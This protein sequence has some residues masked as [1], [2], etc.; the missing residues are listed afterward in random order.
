MESYYFL[1]ILFTALWTGFGV[2]CYKNFLHN[3]S[4]PLNKKGENFLPMIVFL[5]VLLRIIIGSVY[6]GHKT[7]MGCFNGWSNSVY[8]NGISNF[9][10]S[11]SFHD[12]PPGY[13]YVLFIIGWL[14]DL[15]SPEGAMLTLLLKAP[16]II[17]DILIGVLIYKVSCEKFAKNTSSII[18]AL[19][20]FNP[21][22]IVD[23]TFWGQV[24]SVY[25]LFMVI[26]VIL[27]AKKKIIPAAFTFA[28]CIFIKPQSIMLT[29]LI[30]LAVFEES[31][32][33][34]FDIKKLSIY[35][36]SGIAA[37]LSI[38]VIS[39]PFG[40][41]AVISQ[42][43]DTLGSYPYDTVNAFNLWGLIGHNWEKITT[44]TDIF[45]YASI[46]I[47]CI[48]TAVLFIKTKAEEKYYYLGAFLILATFTFS[49]HMHERYAFAAMPLILL[50][51]SHSKSF[52]DYMAY[53][54]VT[55]SHFF[56][57]AWVLFIYETDINKFFRSPVINIASAVNIAIFIYFAYNI[58]KRKKV[59]VPDF[60]TAPK[61][62]K[63]IKPEDRISTTKKI[64]KIDKI[65][66][67]VMAAITVIYSVVAFA[68]LGDMHAPETKYTLNNTVTLDL[69]ETKSI[70]EVNF[71]IAPPNLDDNRNINVVGLDENLNQVTNTS[72]GNGAV[73]VYDWTPIAINNN[74][75]YIQ[76]S[77]NQPPLNIIE[78]GVRDANQNIVTPVNAS[79]YA[80]MFD[81]QDLVPEYT[82]FMNSSYFDEIYHARTAKEFIDGETIYE[83]THPPLG[84]LLI[85]IGILIFGMNP[86]GWRFM[87]TLFGIL[88]VSIIYIFIK[89]VFIKRSIAIFGCLLFTFD[90]MHFVQSRISTVDVYATTFI[91][92]MF[93][94]M[95]IYVSKS[96]YDTDLKKTFVPLALSGIFFG[97]SVSCKWNSAYAAVGLALVFFWSLY[98]RYTEYVF[99]KKT[100]KGTTNGI[101]HKHIID[102]FVPNTTK[103][104]GWCMIFFVALPLVIYA[105]SYIPFMR[106]QGD[107]SLGVIL[108]NQ[109]DMF[110]YHSR[111]V[112][113]STHSFSSK[114]Y[115]WLIMKRPVWFYS[116]TYPDGLKGGISTFGNPALWW[117]GLVA[118]LMN[119]YYAYSKRDKAALFLLVAYIAQIV[120]W[121]PIGRTTYIYH[122]FPM[123]PFLCLMLCNC[124]KHSLI[125]T[126]GKA[127]A[128]WFV[129]AAIGV[130]LFIM[131]YPVLS[132]VPVSSEYVLENLKWFDTWQL[133]P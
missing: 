33:P 105:L 54:L 18:S 110:I 32:Y 43:T 22:I 57:Y 106:A 15:F 66:V 36:L 11:D 52:K 96:F 103:T 23:S 99:A 27:L 53:I 124:M 35:V 29:P 102:S 58:I 24:D 125:N 118:V 59:S 97:L 9:Y 115:E 78:L 80:N 131:F 88:M 17:C 132:G 129:Y 122:Y 21:A 25:T 104:I 111:T 26:Y 93:M 39:L 50:A 20:M 6:F 13:M 49:T 117:G 16:A 40:L 51:F 79:Q 1:I 14:R 44:P 116:A 85:S 48:V 126:K 91:M 86:F 10:T 70:K 61:K 72:H 107:Y 128:V 37:I 38:F 46:V 133:I 41:G 12:Y 67:I 123:V 31:I 76:I 112:K 62:P 119:I 71:F 100:P 42:Y 114:W 45:G 84:K 87:G 7:D 56:N 60:I 130:G 74:I 55:A 8:Q 68:N 65:D 83:W 69:G 113:A 94:F 4:K 121:L 3:A 82:S 63:I 101:S 73:Y 47:A 64:G 120:F 90:F 5:A 77:S 19:W 108:D 34:K 95:Y 30:L 127:T 109:K 2:Y 81:E 92:L 98:K 75:K 89:K 28:V